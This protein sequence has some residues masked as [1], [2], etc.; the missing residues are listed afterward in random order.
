MELLV[1]MSALNPSNS[2][3]FY[4]ARKVLRLAKF[5]PNDISS[6]D[7]RRLEFQ[8]DTFIDDIKKDDRF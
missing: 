6:S 8:I 3:A 4:D 5:Y 1:C 2:F 7:L